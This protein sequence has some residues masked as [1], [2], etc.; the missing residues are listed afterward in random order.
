MKPATQSNASNASAQ[1]C[2]LATVLILGTA[3]RFAIATRGHNFDFESYRVV[4]DLMAQG[5]NVYAH[6]AR[7]NYGPV[8]FNVLHA[9]D[10][11]A[12]RDANLF[13]WLLIGLLTAADAGIALILWR[14]FDKWAA[15]IFFLNPV[16]IIITGFT[17]QFDNVAILMG[18]GAMWL[19][20]D[21]FDR[22]A[23]RKKFGGLLLLGL[24]LMTKHLLFAL[25]FW[26]AIKQRGWR[27]KILVLSVPVL[28]FLMGFAPYWQAGH[29]GIVDHVFK[30]RSMHNPILYNLLMPE[31]FC[32][33]I[34]S[35][36][37]WFASLAIIA[38]AARHRKILDCFGIYLAVMV[39]TAPS[40]GLQYLA[41]PLFFTAMNLNVLTIL[42][43]LSAA[44]VITVNPIGLNVTG[45]LRPL[46]PTVPI[47]L[48]ALALVWHLW[49][50]QLIAN[51]HRFLQRMK[52]K[53]A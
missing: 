8:W 2:W 18:L 43:S 29:Q 25:P 21:E 38:Y 37:F 10:F 14:R 5:Q 51:G 19:I 36:M 52:S 1:I 49:K 46:Q 53:K 40:V 13:R 42:Y 31:F 16:S 33:I 11:V 22:P 4:A 34:S 17:N 39:A 6:T 32:G 47:C 7:Y 9:L 45:F 28:I 12:G 44:I 30:Y 41:I 15:T 24:S 50:N 3:A 35:Q 23:S 27:Q 20:E 26:I 48:L